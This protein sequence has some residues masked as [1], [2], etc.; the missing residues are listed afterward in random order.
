MYM[1]NEIHV[2]LLH[3]VSQSATS[4][5]L[6][7]Y[8]HDE[9]ISHPYGFTFRRTL[10][11]GHLPKFPHAQHKPGHLVAWMASNCHASNGREA[12]VRHL[13]KF[14]PVKTF[15]GCGEKCDM[16]MKLPQKNF[17][18]VSWLTRHRQSENHQ[19]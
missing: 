2:A 7:R 18:P 4:L 13:S 8:R 10:S 5:T 15:G 17:R 11:K 9:D 14:I 1:Y 12:Y 16:G 3:M 19:F 6:I